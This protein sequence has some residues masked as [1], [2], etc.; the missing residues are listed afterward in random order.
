MRASSV[1]LA[2]AVTC[3][4]SSPCWFTLPAYSASPGALSASWLSPVMGAWFTALSP[5]VTVPSSGTRAPGAMRSVAPSGTWAAFWRTVLPSGCSTSALSGARSSRL[6]MAWRARSMAP[7]SMRSAA[8]YSAITMAASGH[9]PMRKAPVTATAISAWMPRRSRAR[10]FKPAR[11]T[12]RPARAMAA[13]ASNMPGTSYCAQCAASAPAAKSRAAAMRGQPGRAPWPC[14][15]LLQ[16][17][18][19]LAPCV[20]LQALAAGAAAP[21]AWLPWSCPWSWAGWGEGFA[22]F[23]PSLES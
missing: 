16:P 23:M 8:T 6:R 10:S 3:I 7:S 12:P 14:G 19:A 20:G 4:S 9:W 21:C 1:P 18:Q 22:W 5:R 11:Y 13:T 17:Q 2:G 15:S